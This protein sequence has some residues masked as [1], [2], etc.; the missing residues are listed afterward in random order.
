MGFISMDLIGPF[1]TT[2]RENQYAKMVICMITNYI[3]CV[4]LAEKSADI[5]VNAP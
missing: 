2:S 1:G 5:V 3:L 4:P